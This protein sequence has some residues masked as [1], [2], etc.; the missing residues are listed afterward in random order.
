LGGLGGDGY[1]DGTNHGGGPALE[2]SGG[3]GGGAARGGLLDTPLATWQTDEFGG[4]GSFGGGGGFSVGPLGGGGGSDFGGGGGG[5]GGSVLGT[6]LAGSAGGEA[7]WFGG[8]GGVGDGVAPGQ[9]GGGGGLGGAIFLRAGT[10]AMY[11]C[12]F[13]DNQALPG[14]GDASGGLLQALPEGKGGAVF[15]FAYDSANEAPLYLDLLQAQSYSGNYAT[16]LVESPTFDNDDYY[17]AQI[18]FPATRRGSSLE[19]LYQRYHQ[20]RKLGLPWVR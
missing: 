15:V 18:A 9:G 14:T 7:A 16:D 10:L 13:N 8:D 11:Q 20:A 4:D 12:V 19:L 2:G 17:I 3:G 5:S 6:V 1:L